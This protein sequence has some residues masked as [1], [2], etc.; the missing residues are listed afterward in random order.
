VLLSNIY[1]GTGNWDKVAKVKF[2]ERKGGDKGT[3]MQ[4]D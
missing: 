3:R 4:L 2:D 1:A